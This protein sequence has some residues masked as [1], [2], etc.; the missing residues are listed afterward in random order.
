MIESYDLICFAHDKKSVQYTPYCVGDTFSYQ[1]FENIL[2]TKHYVNN[3]IKTFD[4]NPRLGILS[5]PPPFH[6]S[7]FIA[8]GREWVHNFE[9]TRELA[10]RLKIEVP[11]SEDKPPVAPLGTMFWF[12][13]DAL[14]ILCEENLTYAD[15]PQEP[16]HSDG[17]ILHAYE[18][19]YPYAAQQS[20]Y[21]AG[22][23]MTERYS[24]IQM[25]AHYHM[26]RAF[27]YICFDRVHFKFNSFNMLLSKLDKK[28]NRDLRLVI[29]DFYPIRI[30]WRWIR[31]MI[32]RGK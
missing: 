10:D 21:F 6:A 7:L 18:R 19:I 15:F 4:A 30:L 16:N 11:I 32:K 13:G 26:L 17:T 1:C 20:G 27:G 31:P 25:N 2:G 9:K 5:P 3:I 24:K 14:K 8:I 12:R 22:H 28:F 29:R 23:C